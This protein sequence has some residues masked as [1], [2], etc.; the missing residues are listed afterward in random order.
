M[1]EIHFDES[2]ICPLANALEIKCEATTE[3]A[4]PCGTSADHLP[5]L[6]LAEDLCQRAV[7]GRAQHESQPFDEVEAQSLT[8][9][10]ERDLRLAWLCLEQAM[11]EYIERSD[12]S[13]Y[14]DDARIYADRVVRNS[15]TKFTVW[16]SASLL[17]AFLP[18]FRSETLGSPEAGED[19]GPQFL[20]FARKSTAR[21][22]QAARQAPI[23]TQKTHPGHIVSANHTPCFYSES[24]RNGALKKMG[25]MLLALRAGLKI[26]PGSV[27]ESA[28]I[29]HRARTPATGYSH[30]YYALTASSHKIPV[31]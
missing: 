15:Q 20:Q 22:G 23:H 5:P 24:G 9:E 3:G 30:D 7:A 8:A 31:K 28:V 29:S 21:L 19:L 14:F 13:D 4:A 11:P 16:Q 10:S 17:K 6:V 1:G 27:R 18:L 26:Y 12:A 25:G 2:A